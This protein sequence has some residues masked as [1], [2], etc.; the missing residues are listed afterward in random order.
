M[1]EQLGPPDVDMSLGRPKFVFSKIGLTSV[2]SFRDDYIKWGRIEV[3]WW[4]RVLCRQLTDDT[5]P[6]RSDSSQ[7]LQVLW[8][9]WNS[10]NQIQSQVGALW[11][12]T[13]KLLEKF[14]GH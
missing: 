7:S 4:G 1:F 2:V 5:P 8:W 14:N 13:N 3:S 10:I 11:D 6:S 9:A 12:Y